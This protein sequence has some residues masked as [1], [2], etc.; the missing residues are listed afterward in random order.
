MR[1][2]ITATLIATLMTATNAAADFKVAEFTFGQ[3]G[4][5]RATVVESFKKF[6]TPAVAEVKSGL[7]QVEINQMLKNIGLDK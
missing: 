3:A 6:Q 7:S 5:T 2:F 1:T 4:S